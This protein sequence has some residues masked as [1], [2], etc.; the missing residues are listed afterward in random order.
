MK[1]E[2]SACVFHEFFDFSAKGDGLLVEHQD[3]LV[4]GL[5]HTPLTVV[6]TPHCDCANLCDMNGCA[7]GSFHGVTEEERPGGTVKEESED[8]LL[9]TKKRF[10]LDV[11]VAVWLLPKNFE[12]LV[13]ARAQVVDYFGVVGLHEILHRLACS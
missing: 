13:P 9:D 8:M 7:T 1:G 6:L 4:H 3:H 10:K 11:G 2:P 5:R 12:Y